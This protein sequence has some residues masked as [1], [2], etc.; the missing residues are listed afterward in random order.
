MSVDLEKG[1][2]PGAGPGPV[3]TSVTVA[4][5]VEVS[6][7]AGN[8]DGALTPVLMVHGLAS[9]AR[10]WDGVAAELAA[11]GHP[12]AAVDQRG[13]GRSAKP[14]GGYDFETLTAD[15]VTV[16]AALG[17][18]RRPPMVAGQSWGGNVVLDLAA[19]HP[20]AVSGLTLVDGGT[21]E[22]S[23]RFADWPTCEA[24]LAPP[25][26]A[27]TRAADFER[28]IRSHHP[29]WPE[30]GIAGTLANMEVRDDG[31]IAPW[32]SRDNHMRILR[33]LWEHRP[34]QLYPQVRT[35]VLMLMAADAAN[36]R[37][38]AGKKDEVVAAEVGLA[39]SQ[40][41]WIEGDHD[42]HAQFPGLVAGLIHTA[43]EAEAEAK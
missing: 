38:M 25:P 11:A 22:L 43:A 41:H 42:L 28:L 13:H 6:L 33:N 34:R 31:T 4:D 14:T 5:G 26:L 19:R 32:L 3:R 8:P 2:W 7:I 1:S 16:I 12:V 35:A 21:I 15:L 18:D 29:S 36:P 39:R 20:D 10:L 17:W 30:T 40:T 24:A 9:N 37:W 27:G 23:A